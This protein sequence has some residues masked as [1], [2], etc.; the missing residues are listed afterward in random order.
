MHTLVCA[1]WR[2]EAAF[3]AVLLERQPRRCHLQQVYNV[4]TTSPAICRIELTQSSHE[5]KKKAIADCAA[6]TFAVERYDLLV[7]THA[8]SR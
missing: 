3:V 1:G 4:I 2:D 6:L 5:M 7:L 8:C